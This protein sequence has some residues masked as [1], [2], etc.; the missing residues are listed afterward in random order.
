[1][2]RRLEAPRASAFMFMSPLTATLISVVFLG[3]ELTLQFLLG[4]LLIIT[5]IM[6]S[7]KK[8]KLLQ[9]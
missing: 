9:T 2:M 3:D 8:A 1:A 7:Q 5:G 4:S 6:L